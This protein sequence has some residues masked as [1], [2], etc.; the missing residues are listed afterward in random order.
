MKIIYGL[1]KIFPVKHKALY[2]S[3]QNN[4][5]PED[6]ILLS[7]EFAKISPGIKNV[8]ICKTI[9]ETYKEKFLYIFTIL[10][11]MRHLATAEYCFLDGYSIPVSVLKHKKRLIISQIWHSLGAVKKFGHQS[12][13]KPDAR[14]GK[15]AKLMNMHKNYTFVFC[16][17]EATG[18]IYAEAFGADREKVKILGFPRIDSILSDNNKI[19][20]KI[21]GRYPIFKEKANIFYCPTFRKDKIIDINKVANAFDHTKFNLIVKLHPLDKS[22]YDKAKAFTPP[23]SSTELLTVADYVITDYSALC[24]E[25]ALL[26]KPVFFYL[27]DYGDY[28]KERGLNIDP[29]AEFPIGASKNIEAISKIIEC[30]GYEKDEII[31]FRNKYVTTADCRNAERI[32]EFVAS[33]GHRKDNLNNA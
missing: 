33:A 20:D 22:S 18:D 32:I 6:F 13:D 2:L 26:N 29:F 30:G 10:N 7:E 8:Y 1:L 3:R 24:F 16:A 25:A 23:F 9:G 21:L 27:Y 17:S 28:I 5:I 14:S 19:R 11:M 31:K 12:L 15:T 4:N